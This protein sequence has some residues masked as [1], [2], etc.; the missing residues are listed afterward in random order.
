[1]T[2]AA[3]V[4]VG[5]L[6][7]LR[8]REVSDA[9][10][11][12]RALA[13]EIAAAKTE[14]ASARE[15]EESFRYAGRV[16]AFASALDAGI[17]P[18]FEEELGAAPEALRG[19]EWRH[20]G[21]RAGSLASPAFTLPGGAVRHVAIGPD[22]S[23]GISLADDARLR[24]WSTETGA[25]LA[26][27]EPI[28]GA[29]AL[30]LSSDGELA[31]IATAAGGVHVFRAP[32]LEPAWSV[33]LHP[34]A[35][36]R[37]APLLALA[38][39]PRALF[40]VA[41]GE[42]G[43]ATVLETSG[44]KELAD[45]RPERGRIRAVQGSP[46][47]AHLALAT[48]KGWLELY[49][50]A[51]FAREREV[52]LVPSTGERAL[53]LRAVAFAPDGKSLA[54][55]GCDGLVRILGTLDAQERASSRA[56]PACIDALAFAAAGARLLVATA[57]GS[58]YWLDAR[59][60]AIDAVTSRASSSFPLAVD[61]ARPLCWTAQGDAVHL[62]SAEDPPG[63]RT[64]RASGSPV[65]ALALSADGAWLAA[66]EASGK[67]WIWDVDP[68]R[69]EHELDGG[70]DARALAWH[71]DGERLLCAR[72]TS[73]LVVSVASGTLLAEREV[74]SEHPL[75]IAS[76]GP[77]E[78]R[79]LTA[80]GGSWRLDLETGE[81]ALSARFGER[82]LAA[83][84]APD[85]TRALL[86]CASGACR[87]VDPETGA[88][89]EHELSS[90]SAAGLALDPGGK[91]AFLVDASGALTIADVA[92]GARLGCLRGTSRWMAVATS[93]D[94]ECIATAGADGSLVLWETR[95]DPE[96]LR[97]RACAK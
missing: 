50:G 20:L 48:E 53:P 7:V 27:S 22:G 96:S 81:T 1:V 4:I 47:G 60:A 54:V 28:A 26:A 78:A 56:L 5:V 19:W 32:L 24:T 30:A 21:L 51:G 93:A 45:L 12:T 25:V 67:L 89:L 68:A 64:L 83:A 16:Q 62:A 97:R 61:P 52:Q 77:S 87:L 8:T 40:L 79:V 57:D 63:R 71:P 38:F 59:S 58:L 39:D 15:R 29:T 6:A 18:S 92:T 2:L 17:L 66:S 23:F 11:A 49:D 14:L 91:R 90:A 73:V 74:S 9:R 80:E 95:C 41:A 69:L 36:G 3:L 88:E 13:V 72:G 76:T 33:V 84:V 46:D 31:A 44:G 10:E 94:G 55:A 75:A 70:L 37:G 35:E 85:G 65:V 34:D 42:A 43:S 86:E 82:V